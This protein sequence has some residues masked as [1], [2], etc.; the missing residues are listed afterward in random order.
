MSA[1][2]ETAEESFTG[3]IE[4]LTLNNNEYRK[5]LYTTSTMQLV[6]MNLHP[7]E[8]IGTETHSN[9]TQ[10]IRIEDGD[11][12]AVINGKNINMKTN[13]AIVIPPGTEHNI[14]NTSTKHLKLYTIYSPPEHPKDCVQNRKT[15]TYCH[16]QYKSIK[17]DYNKIK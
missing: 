6:L 10:F 3:N 2:Y 13:D 1:I 16:D 4:E 15:S 12:L 8:E 14:I 9:T 17:G 7:N 11:A 5:V